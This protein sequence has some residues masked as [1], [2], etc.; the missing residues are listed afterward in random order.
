MKPR[1]EMSGRLSGK[2]CINESLVTAVYLLF[3]KL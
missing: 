1:V 2:V 3:A